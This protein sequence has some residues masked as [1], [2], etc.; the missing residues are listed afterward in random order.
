MVM[1]SM[2][3][4]VM[5]Q[6]VTATISD[7]Y[8]INAAFT[9]GL[10]PEEVILALVV[11]TGVTLA[12]TLMATREL[13]SLAPADAMRPWVDTQG[14]DSVRTMTTLAGA[15]LLM[16]GLAAAAVL[17]RAT[18]E[19]FG[20]PT[21]PIWMGAVWCALLGVSLLLSSLLPAVSRLGAFLAPVSGAVLRLGLG[22]LSRAQVRNGATVAAVVIAVA[23]M[24]GIGGQ[25]ASFKNSVRKWVEGTIKWDLLVTT[26]FAGTTSD[27]DM[28]ETMGEELRNVPGVTL[29]SPEKFA[30]ARLADGRSVAVWAFVFEEFER[31]A[32]LQV[33]AGESSGL[34][35]TLSQ[36]KGV[37]VSSTFAARSGLKLGDAVRFNTPGGRLELPI[38]A[39]VQDFGSDLGAIY[40]DR[41]V[42]KRYWRDHGVSAFAV[43]IRD[44][45][46]TEALRRQIEQGFGE[47]WTLSVRTRGQFQEQVD[48]LAD[49]AFALTEGLIWIAVLVGAFGV[50]NT[51][52]IA[53]SER[54]RELAVMQAVGARPGV[55]LRMVVTEA[56]VMGM[57]GTLPGLGCG[58]LMWEALIQGARATTGMIL[59]PAWSQQLLP[60]VLAV[61]FVLVPMAGLIPGW[62]A[63]RVPL[64]EAMRY[65]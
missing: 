3:A 52:L 6:G 61:V 5:V 65:E 32:L 33:V 24:A 44:R 30:P 58:Y 29:A 37:A 46:Q 35:E 48:A 17:S 53:I 39:L 41:S 34:Y 59:S 57:V 62:L 51:L 63:M 15:A 2:L 4:Q 11:G 16:G 19:L 43:L 10:E 26:S 38:F 60:S 27:V 47:K 42:Y 23:M 55:V 21:V 54:R 25:T 8:R 28:P 22:N 12:A 9:N 49:Q 14:S 31:F 20:I 7:F 50:F 18:R 36:G 64:S 40:M 13:A 56:T 1:G 45:E